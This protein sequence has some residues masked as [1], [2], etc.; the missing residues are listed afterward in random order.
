MYGFNLFS[1]FANLSSHIFVFSLCG[2]LLEV[3]I[4]LHGQKL[5]EFWVGGTASDVKGDREDFE[6]VTA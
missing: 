1:Q 5:D 4:L 3:Y 6:R 2:L